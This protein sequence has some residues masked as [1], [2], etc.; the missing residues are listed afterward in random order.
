MYDEEEIEPIRSL[1][2]Q[3][4]QSLDD[5]P[6]TKVIYE[7]RRRHFPDPWGRPAP[8]TPEAAGDGRANQLEARGAR[9]A[10]VLVL[11]VEGDRIERS[12]ADQV[13][14]VIGEVD[15]LHCHALG[16]EVRGG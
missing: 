1:S 7:L 13:V 4:L 14:E 5:D 9:F 8:G 10:N 3:S 11:G 2:L 15:R 16:R 6:G 12:E